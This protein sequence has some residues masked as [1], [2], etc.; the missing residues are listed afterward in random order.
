MTAVEPRTLRRVDTDGSCWWCKG[1]GWLPNHD[2]CSCDARPFDAAP[3]PDS[4]WARV[5]PELGPPA[6]RPE[7]A[8]VARTDLED[9]VDAALAWSGGVL[10]AVV[11]LAEWAPYLQG[12]GLQVA[13]ADRVLDAALDLHAAADDLFVLADRLRDSALVVRNLEAA[14]RPF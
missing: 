12:G 9:A 10:S 2:P 3:D 7:P 13:A 6:P 5:G 1:T 14:R 11:R 4:P 8:I